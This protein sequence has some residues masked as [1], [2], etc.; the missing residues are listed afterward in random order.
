MENPYIASSSLRLG[1]TIN[2]PQ[3]PSTVEE[4]LTGSSQIK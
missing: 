3:Q 1:A 2:L 4:F